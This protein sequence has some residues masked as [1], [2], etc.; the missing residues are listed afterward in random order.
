MLKE[1]DP[2]VMGTTAEGDEVTF[3][4]L[5]IVML[6]L[7]ISAP[8]IVTFFDPTINGYRSEIVPV[9]ITKRT[10]VGIVYVA[11]KEG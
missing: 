7:S 11:N 6:Q 3:M 1:Q 2:V 8:C 4:L 5:L 10:C 9:P